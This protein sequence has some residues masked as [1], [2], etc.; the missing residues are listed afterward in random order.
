ME[1]L[2]GKKPGEN[3]GQRETRSLAFRLVKK[4]GDSGKLVRGSPI[5]FI[6]GKNITTGGKKKP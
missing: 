3:E 2:L 1:G 5:H 6:G 4:A